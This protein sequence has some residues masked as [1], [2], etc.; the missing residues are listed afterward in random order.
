M[1]GP[2][3]PGASIGAGVSLFFALL[4]GIAFGWF[5]ERGGMGSARRLAAQ[6]YLRDLAVFKLMFSAILTAML[7]A[8]WLSRLGVLDLSR[9]WMPATYIA[10][11]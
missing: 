11:M 4:L 5:L 10:T 8:F 6:F 7:G 2:L 3:V 9:V 1:S